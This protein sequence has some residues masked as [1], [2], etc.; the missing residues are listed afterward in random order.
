MHKI[1]DGKDKDGGK[2]GKDG[3]DGGKDADKADKDK[4]DKDA[5]DAKDG[6]AAAS[7]DAD[8][9]KKRGDTHL[10]EKFLIK[11]CSMNLHL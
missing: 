10:L 4:A 8:A 3:K 11:R 1:D 9:K 5:E 2:D 7:R 6:A